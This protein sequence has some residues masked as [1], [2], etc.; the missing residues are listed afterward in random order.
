MKKSNPV[1][2]QKIKCYK[3]YKHAIGFINTRPL[4]E[5]HYPYIPRFAN[6]KFDYI[7]HIK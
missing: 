4:C 6:N 3:C 1:F 5:D 7:K 2:K